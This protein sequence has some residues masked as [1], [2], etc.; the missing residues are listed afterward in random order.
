[1]SVPA[2]WRTRRWLLG[3]GVSIGGDGRVTGLDLSEN[4]LTGELPPALGNLAGLTKL[5]LSHNQLEG[6]IPTSL[7]RMFG[8]TELYPAFQPTQRQTAVQRYS[9][10]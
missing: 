6:E 1:M 8:L 4:G 5:D 3:A 2:G 10:P 9:Q 7:A